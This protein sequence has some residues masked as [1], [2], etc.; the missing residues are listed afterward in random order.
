MVRFAIAAAFGLL[1]QNAAS[2]ADTLPPL[3]CEFKAGAA[4]TYD[5]GKFKS[6]TPSPLSFDLDSIDLDAQSATIEMGS[7][8]KGGTLRVI[9]AI[10]ANHFLEVVNEGFLNLTTV[11][12]K[13]PVTGLRPAVHSRHFGIWGTPVVALYT[14]TC[15]EK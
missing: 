10:N 1:L 9:R 7:G 8:E 11:Y 15:R 3:A 2:A 13:D 14:G 4:W 5:A 12:D 6:T